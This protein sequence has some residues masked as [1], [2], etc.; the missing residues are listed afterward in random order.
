[1]SATTEKQSAP[2]RSR[3][4]K[5]TKA[6]TKPTERTSPTKTT[7]ELKKAEPSSGYGGRKEPGSKKGHTGSKG[8]K[9]SKSSGSDVG[10]LSSGSRKEKEAV[11]ESRKRPPSFEQSLEESFAVSQKRRRKS[12]E[13]T[14]RPKSGSSDSSKSRKFSGSSSPT[15]LVA[16]PVTSVAPPE[17]ARDAET[18][19]A[20]P[21]ATLTTIAE[22]DLSSTLL[23]IKVEL[24]SVSA[25][26][27]QV[28]QP[29]SPSPSLAEVKG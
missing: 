23:C 10:P 13:K 25:E 12:G 19:V 5:T 16:A 15:E 3:P 27:S 8:E 4:P 7:K 17:A 9:K 6:P 20:V 1:M 22:P 11:I 28:Q 21:A 26:S 24:E 2:K 29:T 14:P 18:T